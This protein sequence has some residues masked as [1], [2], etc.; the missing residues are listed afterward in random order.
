MLRFL[1]VSVGLCLTELLVVCAGARAAEPSRVLVVN[2]QDA[3]VSLVNLD[4]MKEEKRFPVGK[5][6]YGIAVAP[7]GTTVAVGVEDEEAV[8][9]FSLPDFEHKGS[10]PIGKMHNDHLV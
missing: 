6:P 5:R 3:S 10:V 7:D 4:S 1:S 9:F 8:K 2:T